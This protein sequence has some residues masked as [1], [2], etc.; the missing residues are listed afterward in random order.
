MT[1]SIN[2]WAV[3]Y[4]H[5]SALC[6]DDLTV[7]RMPCV[8]AGI[9]I[10]ATAPVRRMFLLITNIW[11]TSRPCPQK[12]TVFKLILDHLPSNTVFFFFQ[13]LVVL[14]CTQSKT[15]RKGECSSGS[16]SPR[17]GW[18]WS[19]VSAEPVAW[20]SCRFPPDLQ[21]YFTVSC[22]LTPEPWAY[23]TGLA[24]GICLGLLVD[25]FPSLP[26]YPLIWW[27]G[28]RQKGKGERKD[29]NISLLQESLEEQ[30]WEDMAERKWLGRPWVCQLHV[31]LL[32]L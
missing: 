9:F 27:L 16:T 21:C 20:G 17:G 25:H 13:S 6:F 14:T 18:F 1:F 31:Y 26:I 32:R 30:K 8:P 3:I 23:A 12:A 4:F 5:Y 10:A 2:I 15:K 22:W 7:D 19:R 29:A 24:L 11:W 28:R